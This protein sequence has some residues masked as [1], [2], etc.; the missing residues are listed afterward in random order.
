MTFNI[1]EFSFGL[2]KHCFF[3]VLIYKKRLFSPVYWI[4]ILQVITQTVFIN[5]C[6]WRLLLCSHFLFFNH[7]LRTALLISYPLVNPSAH[8]VW[9]KRRTV[10]ASEQLSTVLRIC[11]ESSCCLTLRAAGFHVRLFTLQ[12]GNSDLIWSNNE[13]SNCGYNTSMA[14]TPAD[15]LQQDILGTARVKQNPSKRFPLKPLNLST[16]RPTWAEDHTNT[17]NKTGQFY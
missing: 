10:W 3:G 5:S 12:M 1:V 14:L 11:S 4:I 2:T 9:E 16:R 17:S 8:L 15:W 13:R 7:F 6:V